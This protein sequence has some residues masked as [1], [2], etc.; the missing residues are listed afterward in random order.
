MRVTERSYLP[1]SV[2]CI[3]CLPSL[4]TDKERVTMAK[5]ASPV[6]IYTLEVRLTSGLATE[7]FAK[8]NPVVSRTIEMRGD[9]TLRTLHNAIFRAFDRFDEHM[10]EFQMS[11]RPMGKGARYGIP[12]DE[13]LFALLAPVQQAGDAGKTSLDSLAL[14]PKQQFWYWFDF[15]DD[16]WHCIT[17]KAIE[18]KTPEGKYP[19]VTERV[20][21]SPPQ[22]VDWDEEDEEEWEEE[23]EE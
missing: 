14:K 22:Y 13:P 3:P 6:R 23:E 7:E 4:G 12:D 9:Q 17:V 19:R 20:G 16:W 11:K 15:G 18:E 5:S 8:A 1:S 21:A 2:A 10:Y